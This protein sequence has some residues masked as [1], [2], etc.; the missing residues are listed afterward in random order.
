MFNRIKTILDAYPVVIFIKGIPQDPFCKY[1]RSFI[2]ELNA[3]GLNYR[4]FDIFKDED[5]RQW[6]R[7]YSGWKT[8]PQLYVNGKIVGGLDVTR[9]LIKNGE[10]LKMVPENLITKK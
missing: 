7:L 5:I 2:E 10:L 8:Y 6:L 4:S 1:S 9:E 3:L